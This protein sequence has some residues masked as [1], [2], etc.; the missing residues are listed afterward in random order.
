MGRDQKPIFIFASGQRCG[1]T[2]IQRLLNSHKEILLWGEQNGLLNGFIKDYGKLLDWAQEYG[3][4]RKTYLT[5]GYDNFTANMVPTKLEIH[6]AAKVFIETLFGR[7]AGKLGKSRW[8]FKEVRYDSSIAIILKQFYPKSAIIHLTR[9]VIDCFISLKHWENS[10]GPWTR[11]WTEIFIRDW[12]RINSS[13]LLSETQLEGFLSIKYEDLIV[14][15]EDTLQKL[16]SYLGVVCEDLD[17]TIFHRRLHREGVE[18]TVE[19][20]IISRSSLSRSERD[21]LTRP[22]IPDISR[23]LGYDLDFEKNA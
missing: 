15:K 9:N 14:N 19:R 18:G 20:K 5:T 8:G 22:P 16:C 13:F 2:L 6:R 21:L 11:T 17:L 4:H 7:P 23:S 1:S 12:Q 10:A 3:N